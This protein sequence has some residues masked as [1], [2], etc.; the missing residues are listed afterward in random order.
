MK[1]K[2]SII[3]LGLLFLGKGCPLF[4]QFFTKAE[5]Q[6]IYEEVKTPYKYG[7]IMAPKDNYHKMDCPTVFQEKGKWYMTYVVYNGKDGLDGRGYETWQAESPDLLH[8]KTLGRV[9]SYKSCGWDMNQR[10]GGPF[11]DR[12]DM[13]WKLSDAEIQRPPLD[14]LYWRSRNRL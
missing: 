6:A 4:A 10:G 9:L 12:L 13:G 1:K 3:L 11:S 2:Y 5:M 14:D 8:W 7:M